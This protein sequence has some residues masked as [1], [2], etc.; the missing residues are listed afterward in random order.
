MPCQSLPVLIG[1]EQ[2]FDMDNRTPMLK[3]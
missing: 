1:I 2:A 3:S